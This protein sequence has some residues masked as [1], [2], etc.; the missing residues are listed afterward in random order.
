MVVPGRF[1]PS[2]V[3]NSEFSLNPDIEARY[4]IGLLEFSWDCGLILSAFGL[5]A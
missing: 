4:S 2:R 5:S 1:G 3:P